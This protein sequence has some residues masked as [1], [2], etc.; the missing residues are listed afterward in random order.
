MPADPQTTAQA[1]HPGDE[2][3]CHRGMFE[4][5]GTALGVGRIPGCYQVR[6]I[7]LDTMDVPP[8]ELRLISGMN[9]TD[10]ARM[11]ALRNVG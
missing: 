3:G 4:R 8:S 9:A 10:Q 5:P 7:G 6:I 11:G 1:F 2:V